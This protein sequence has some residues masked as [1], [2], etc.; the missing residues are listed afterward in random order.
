MKTISVTCI[1]GISKSQTWMTEQQYNF[2]Q[3]SKA[4][5]LLLLLLSH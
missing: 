4:Q 3:V 1:H 5:L 2:T